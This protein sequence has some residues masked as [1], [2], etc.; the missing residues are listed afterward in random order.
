[1]RVGRVFSP[2]GMVATTLRETVLTTATAD[3]SGSV[4]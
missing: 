4:T 1:M 3:C 2:V